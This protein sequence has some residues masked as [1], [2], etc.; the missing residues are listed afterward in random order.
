MA[1]AHVRYVRLVGPARFRPVH[2]DVL[3]RDANVSRERTSHR[4]DDYDLLRVLPGRRVDATGSAVKDK[5]S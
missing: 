4:V 1:E 5:S 3:C 2:G